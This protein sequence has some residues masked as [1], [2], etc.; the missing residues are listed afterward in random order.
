MKKQLIGSLAAIAALCAGAFS[1]SAD[2]TT[3][4]PETTASAAETTFSETTAA[5][6]T[7]AEAETTAADT[8]STTAEAVTTAAETESAQPAE[9]TAFAEKTEVTPAD[10]YIS[11]AS[12]GKNVV[13]R[14]KIQVG[15]EDGDEKLTV[16]DALIAVHEKHF[17]GGAKNGYQTAETQWGQ[18]ITRLWGV[19]NNGS[20]SYYLNNKLAGGL[21]DPITAKDELYA[22]N[23][24][25]TANF[26]DQYTYFEPS[27]FTAVESEDITFTLHGIAFDANW[28]PVDTVVE[29]A[30]IVVDGEKTEFKTD[31][32][33]KVKMNLKPGKHTISAVAEDGKTIVPPIATGTISKGE[34]EIYITI[35]DKGD[36]V[37]VTVPVMAKDRDGDFKITIDDALYAIHEEYF[38]GGAAA[39]Y[40][41]VETQYGLSLSKLWGREN[42]LSFGYYVNDEPAYSMLDE[43]ETE[44]HLVAFSYVDTEKFSDLYTFIEQDED[45]T[46]TFFIRGITFDEKGNQK[47]VPVEGASIYIASADEDAV[48]ELQ[49]QEIGIITDKDGKF[50]IS[51]KDLD[52]KLFFVTAISEKQTIVPP[53]L[54]IMVDRDEEEEEDQPSTTGTGGKSTA[55][56]SGNT[57]TTGSSGSKN[58]GNTAKTQNTKEAA[59]N[60]GDRSVTAVALTG[61]L[62]L[63]AAFA[64]RRT[65]RNG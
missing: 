35:S 63:G 3:A 2:E 37:T 40:A 5:V 61:L 14:E 43:L 59:P 9:T 20:C 46:E 29:N 30:V 16:N 13:A 36:L 18:S 45:D 49:A 64:V 25:D 54:H 39:G 56:S 27:E 1:V 38:E 62:A 52:G 32:D 8:V 65:R 23:F 21:S 22:F 47:I 42:D 33:G 6:T 57:K 11:V 28:A 41:T 44:D 4:P 58:N 26:S 31:P 55:N 53:I 7:E 34:E 19:D 10:V 48:Q 50:K 24:A 17:E 15:D 51:K 12:E 60:T